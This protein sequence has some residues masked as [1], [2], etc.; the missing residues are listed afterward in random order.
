MRETIGEWKVEWINTNGKTDELEVLIIDSKLDTMA[1]YIYEGS[2][3]KIPKQLEEKKVIHW[4][5]ILE[6]SVRDRIGAYSLTI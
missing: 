5:K 1:P 2:F 4:G 6:S 3:A